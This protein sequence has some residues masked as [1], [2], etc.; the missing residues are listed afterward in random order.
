MTIFEY[1]SVFISI[2]LALGVVHVL[3]GMVQLFGDEKPRAYW[4]HSLWTFNLLALLAY[5]WWHSFDWRLQEVWTF[6]LFLFVVGYSML[7]YVLC[8]V[9]V[10]A[11]PPGRLDYEEYFFRRHRQIFSCWAALWVVDTI[12][13][14][15]KGPENL[16]RMGG[17]LVFLPLAGVTLAHVAA[18][19]TSNRR[20]HQIWAVAFTLGFIVIILTVTDVFHT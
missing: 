20:F 17:S 19:I 14:I 16:E 15:L 8:V 2:V 12:D 11:N 1:L 4:V 13:T 9:M 7:L 10:P 5:F 3:T 6:P 18:A